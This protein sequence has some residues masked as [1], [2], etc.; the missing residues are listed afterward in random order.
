MHKNKKSTT[1]MIFLVLPD[2]VVDENDDGDADMNVILVD[3][4]FQKGRLLLV[5]V[6]YLAIL[7][8]VVGMLSVMQLHSFRSW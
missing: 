7:W 4:F 2:V 5:R 1:E 3:F 6:H 8:K